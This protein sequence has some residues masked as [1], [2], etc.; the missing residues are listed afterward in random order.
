MCRSCACRIRHRE[1][2]GQKI[3]L[4]LV[5]ALDCDAIAWLDD[6]FEQRRRTFGGADLSG[7]PAD[8][9]GSR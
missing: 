3:G 7:S 8:H 9:R 4:F 6:R 1:G 5:I 2:R